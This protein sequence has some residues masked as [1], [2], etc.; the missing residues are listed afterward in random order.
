MAAS[1]KQFLTI[2]TWPADLDRGQLA[3]KLAQTA[4]FDER[5]L[6]LTLGRRPPAILGSFPA[7]QCH[8]AVTLILNLGGDAFACSL[9]DI[10]ALGPTH[11]I[12]NLRLEHGGLAAD[13]WRGGT[14]RI[15]PADVQI[16]IRAKLSEQQ[17]KRPPIQTGQ[18][19]RNAAIYRTGPGMGFALGG[20]YGLALSI[21]SHQSLVDYSFEKTITTSDKLDIHLT[22]GM[23]YQIDGDKFGFQILG[24]LRGFTDNENI[25]KM[26]ELLAHLA[27]DEIVDPYFSI[28][29]APP[30][31]RQLRLPNMKINK[32]DPAFAF[33]SRW[34]ALMYR[35]VMGG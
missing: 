15:E 9:A 6:V 12:R 25:D 10:E 19:Y 22:N 34:A 20:A 16:L 11:K 32:D 3:Q 21:R 1:R 31:I 17:T 2:I 23:I 30:Q 18:R 26:C 33:Y 13:I 4:G 35:H 14:T 7:D 8:A 5:T 24:D 29:K 27:P 28:W